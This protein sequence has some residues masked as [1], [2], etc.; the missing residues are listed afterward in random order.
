MPL[1]ANKTYISQTR[2]LFHAHIKIKIPMVYGE[3]ILSDA[4]RIMERIDELYNSYNPNSYVSSINN[5]AGNYVAVDNTI[6]KLLKTTKQV[7]TY[8]NGAYD[9]T[10]MPLIKLWGFY[11]TEKLAVPTA[12]EITET[13]QKV[14]YKKIVIKGYQVK[15]AQGQELITGSF[16][17]AYA[18]DQVMKFLKA[19]GI[20]DAIVN[21]GGSTIAAMTDDTHPFWKVNIP[22]PTNP[23]VKTTITLSNECF[24]LSAS[25]HNYLTIGSKKYSHILNSTT[26]YPSDNLQVG[27]LSKSA[28]EGDILSTALYSLPSQS[29]T[30]Y[31]TR[32]SEV[33]H[34]KS[35]LIS[36]QEDFYN[37]KFN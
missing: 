35:Y 23:N 19:A 25:N 28:L 30:S 2:F 32:L 7:S 26:G 29:F 17:K 16:I 27:V 15:I 18:V 31:A 1:I 37:F 22:H 33:F 3:H 14:D 21:A 9:I 4:F 10:A 36:S 5:N 6:I 12:K 8:T 24:S 13:L 11:K 34:F 20:T